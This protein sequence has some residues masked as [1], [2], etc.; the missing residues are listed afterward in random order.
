MQIGAPEAQPELSAKQFL[1]TWVVVLQTF[2]PP[3][4]ELSTHSTQ[5]LAVV[6]QAVVAPPHVVL[7]KQATQAPAP[8]F[9]DVLHTAV[10][11]EQPELS[12]RQVLQ[13]CAAV[14]QT[15]AAPLQ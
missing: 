9:A 12:A 10:A 13:I 3:Q 15:G 8:P 6:S 1:H 2:P 5:T 7:S 4:V 11:P 14:S